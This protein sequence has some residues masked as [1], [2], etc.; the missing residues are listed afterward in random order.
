MTYKVT[1]DQLKNVKEF[2]L[3]NNMLTSKP[4]YKYIGGLSIGVDRQRNSGFI[5]IHKF[6]IIGH[7]DYS[8]A[9]DIDGAINPTL[10]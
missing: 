1:L 4:S 5:D 10:L 8:F 3:V 9:N 6:E 7:E 2:A